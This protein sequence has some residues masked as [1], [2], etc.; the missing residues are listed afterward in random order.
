[1]DGLSFREKRDLEAG[2]EIRDWSS[3]KVTWRAERFGCWS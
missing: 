3:G 2:E 1:M